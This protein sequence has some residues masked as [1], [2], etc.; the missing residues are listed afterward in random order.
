MKFINLKVYTNKRT[1]QSLVMLPKKAFGDK[2]KPKEV[3]V[4][5]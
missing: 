4:K 2:I 3:K 5:W 1:G